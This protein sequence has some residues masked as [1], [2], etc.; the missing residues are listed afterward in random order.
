M[1]SR[2]YFTG[3]DSK[4]DARAVRAASRRLLETVI[5]A[6]GVELGR[7]V[8]VKAHFGEEGNVTYLKPENYDG[9]IDYLEDKGIETSFIE[10]CVLYGGQRCTKEL[11]RKT[12]ERHGF[13]RIPVIFADGEHGEDFAEVR[14][15]KRHFR[16]FKVGRAFLDYDRIIV[17]SHFKGHG[18]AGFGGAMKQLAMGFAAKGGKLAMHMGEKPRIKARDC[19]RCEICKKRCHEDALIID[20]KPRIDHAKCVGCGACISA[21]P[22]QAISIISF[23]SVLK[24][25]GI[26]NPFVE[27]LMEGAYAAQLGKKNIYINFAK[28]ITAGCDCEP[29]KMKPLLGD[30]GIFASTDPVA[31]DKA[32]YDMV[33]E[34]GKAF[35]GAKSFEYAR[36]I[37]LGSPAYELREI[38]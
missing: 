32:C 13:T 3:I 20:E 21:C 14:I 4:T 24:F 33:K 17:V 23:A 7:K 30:V 9:I 18:L 19:K 28:D 10:T 15:D 2:V 25:I 36:Q 31:I 27:K 5:E 1:I 35:R 6:E 34:G 8:P 26:G 29:K 12:A 11:H 38:S 16:S 22:N 37:G